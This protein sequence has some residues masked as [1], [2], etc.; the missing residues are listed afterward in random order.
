MHLVIKYFP[1]QDIFICMKK[2]NVTFFIL[3]DRVVNIIEDK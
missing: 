3:G 1:C 2:F